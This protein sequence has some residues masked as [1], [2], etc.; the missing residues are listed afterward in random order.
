MHNQIMRNDNIC[1]KRENKG[2]NGL[3]SPT[4]TPGPGCVDPPRQRLPAK[5]KRKPYPAILPQP[6]CRDRN[7]AIPLRLLALT[8]FRVIPVPSVS[9]LKSRSDLFFSVRTADRCGNHPRISHMLNQK[10]QTGLQPP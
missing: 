6:V 5:Q 4:H 7:P 8:Q 3:L 10:L 1:Q 2:E 9:C